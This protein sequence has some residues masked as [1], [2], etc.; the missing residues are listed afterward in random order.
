MHKH[1]SSFDAADIEKRRLLCEERNRNV[2]SEWL[3]GEPKS[4]IAQKYGLS[5]ARVAQII[6]KVE[7]DIRK[8]EDPVLAEFTGLS[9]RARNAL[10]SSGL[11]SRDSVRRYVRNFYQNKS[12]YNRPLDI[13]NA[14]IIISREI[15]DWLGLSVKNEF[16]IPYFW[17]GKGAESTALRY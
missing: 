6:E 13:D 4:V 7:R 17:L 5:R 9:V 8:K 14:G 1:A 16:S 12:N 15:L 10:L 11:T 3:A 2:Y